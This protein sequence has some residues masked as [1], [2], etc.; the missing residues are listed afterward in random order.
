MNNR[1][2]FI[3]GDNENE[4]NELKAWENVMW[5]QYTN[6]DNI[7]NDWCYVTKNIN[8]I[9]YINGTR[10]KFIFENNTHYLCD[11]NMKTKRIIFE[12]PYHSGLK[13]PIKKTT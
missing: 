13:K 9:Y 7:E 2:I 8:K 12:M 4:W 1:K 11:L 10:L 5:N 3:Q 6:N